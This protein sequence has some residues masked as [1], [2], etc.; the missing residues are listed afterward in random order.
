[1]WSFGCIIAEIL[2]KKPIMSALSNDE[3]F[4]QMLAFDNNANAE[5]VDSLKIDGLS[6][7]IGDLSS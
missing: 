2:L 6:K 3:I 1:M 7:L 5:D 4:Y